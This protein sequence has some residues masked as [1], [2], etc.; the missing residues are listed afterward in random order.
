MKLP[1][2][3]VFLGALILVI[4]RRIH[5]IRSLWAPVAFGV[6][7]SSCQHFAISQN[8]GGA[9][10]V[11]ITILIFMMTIIL[12]V[13]SYG[14]F[15]ISDNESKEM[16]ISWTMRES[17]FL[18][19]MIIVSFAFGILTLI[20]GLIVGTFMHSRDG[21]SGPVFA[22]ILFIPGAY[23]AS[24][25][26]LAFPLIATKEVTIPEALQNAW[27]MSRHNVFGILLLCV[28]V[29][30]I[31]AAFFALMANIDGLGVIAVVLPWITMPV[32][33]AIIALVFSQLYV[34]NNGL[35]SS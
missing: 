21:V 15:L 28:G 9:I 3:K 14:V 13:R 22:A 4:D 12:A 1:I 30:A 2:V 5:L 23:L 29:P 32:E 11:W 6:S 27:V 26:L 20:A 19:T 17:R 34:P 10:N 18:I 25:V 7:L 35:E 8:E 16:P 24:R 31:L 33:F